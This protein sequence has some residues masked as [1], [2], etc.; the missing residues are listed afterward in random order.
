MTT[1]RT[2]G[3]A[4]LLDTRA[5]A[6]RRYLP[7]AVAGDDRGVHQARV[8]SRRLREAVPVLST[9]LKGSKAK[10]AGR[11]IRRLTRALGTVRELDVTLG[12]LDELATAEDL[13]R[14]ALQEVRLHVVAERDRLRKA[15][16]TEL[17]TVDAEKLDRRLHS[18]STALAADTTGAWRKALASRL[19]SRSR[20]LGA[21]IQTAGQLYVPEHLHQVRIAAKKLRYGLELAVDAGVAAA[22]A[23]VGTVKKAQTI[24]G[25][26]H[27][28]QI[29][30][31]H[32]AAVQAAPN[33]RAGTDEALAAIAGRIE[34]QCRLLHGKFVAAVPALRGLVTGVRAD[35]AGRLTK[36][37]QP[38][39][40][41][42]PRSRKRAGQAS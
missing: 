16:L 30:Q 20:R 39:K 33:A 34:E 7:S 38:L 26:L 29:L 28:L 31:T 9:G 37:S 35:V 22:A 23:H 25:R 10:K 19:L 2:P 4:S 21:A 5:R 8:A 42:L 13:S 18:F 11:K 3:T 41:A 17:A 12:L 14:P 32:V 1:R 40:M 15:M 27:D 24:L 6:L 36:G